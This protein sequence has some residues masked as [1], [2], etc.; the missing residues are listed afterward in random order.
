[1]MTPS[2]HRLGKTLLTCESECDWGLVVKALA[3]HAKD[4][5]SIPH[6]GTMCEASYIKPY[7]LTH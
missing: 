4:L 7:L 6:V 5:V 2:F 1:M 3:H